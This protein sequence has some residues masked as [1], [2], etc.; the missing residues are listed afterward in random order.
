MIIAMPENAITL[1]FIAPM[2]RHIHIKL[3]LA[4]TYVYYVHFTPDFDA[5]GVCAFRA[6]AKF[7]CT[8]RYIHIS[9]VSSLVNVHYKTKRLHMCRSI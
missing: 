4:V 3:N 7:A 6:P 8:L 9:A 2:T 1:P 5:H